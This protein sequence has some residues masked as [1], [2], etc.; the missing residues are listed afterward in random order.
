LAAYG[1]VQ[2]LI[3]VVGPLAPPLVHLLGQVLVQERPDLLGERLL[4][5][6]EDNG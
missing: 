2:L 5:F 4:S 3:H 6:G 1:E